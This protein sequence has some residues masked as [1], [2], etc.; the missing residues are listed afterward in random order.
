[1]E[2][3]NVAVEGGA[4]VSFLFPFWTRWT[5]DTPPG[6]DVMA[7]VV[8]TQL[9]PDQRL[10]FLRQLGASPDVGAAGV[11]GRASHRTTL[12]EIARFVGWTTFAVVLVVACVAFNLVAMSFLL[13]G[14]WTVL[15][16]VFRGLF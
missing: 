4:A 12:R 15:W 10:T 9:D 2:S 16:T 1:M 5:P 3:R 8:G 7:H 6:D 14:V 11:S 13:W